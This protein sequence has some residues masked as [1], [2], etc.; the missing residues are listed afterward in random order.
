MRGSEFGDLTAFLTI[1]DQGNFA[2][3]AAQL[4]LSPSTLSYKIRE[5][6][7]RL[8][9]R[10]LN[11]TTRSISLTDVGNRLAL[12][13]APLVAG[14]DA[15]LEEVHEYAGKPKGL[16]RICCP[17]I[18]MTHYLEPHISA[19]R[20]S[21]PDITL[22]ITVSDVA[23]D[24]AANGFAAGVRS[25][26]YLENDVVAIQLGQPLRRIV[27]AAPAYLETHGIPAEPSDLIKHNCINLRW[28]GSGEIYKWEFTDRAGKDFSISVNGTNITSDSNAMIPMALD[29]LAI[30]YGMEPIPSPYLSSGQLVEIL[31][32]WSSYHSGFALY[33][34]KQG[35][36]PAP[37]RHFVDFIKARN[38]KANQGASEFSDDYPELETA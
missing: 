19:F 5:L 13:L 9:A 8:G 35:E 14:L 27:Y 12:R 38:A 2:R 21:F 16:L 3:A 4:R 23:I 29:G 7:E 31:Q 30:G 22:D 1:V 33:F 10:L 24:I 28:P 6:E 34:H 15:A 26:K 25:N 17:R 32:E 36:I 18:A 11:R 37:L 20:K